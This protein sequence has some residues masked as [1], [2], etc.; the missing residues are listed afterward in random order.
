M[1]SDKRGSTVSR[2]RRF[3]E[4]PWG[5]AHGAR[6]LAWFLCLVSVTLL[7]GTSVIVLSSRPSPEWPWPSYLSLIFPV[8]FVVLGA[9]GA[10]VASRRPKNILGWLFVTISCINSFEVAGRLYVVAFDLPARAPVALV[11]GLVG[12]VGIGLLAAALLLFPDGRLPSPTW[13]P[14]AWV[15]FGSLGGC[16][17]LEGLQP[18][19]LQ[20]FVGV[21]NPIGVPG[22]AAITRQASDAFVFLIGAALALAALSLIVR[23]RRTRG[24]E[25]QQI[26]WLAFAAMVLVGA[27]PIMLG[28]DWYAGSY[29]MLAGLI[30]LPA[31]VGIA[32]LRYRLYDIDVII[33]RTLVYGS[34][35]AVLAGLFAALSIL[36]QRIVLALTGQESQAAVVLA[37]LVVTGLFQPLRSRVQTIVDRRFYRRKYDASQTLER[38]A[39]QLREEVELDR[40]ATGLVGV[41]RDTMQ[42]AHAF[43]WLR[44]TAGAEAVRGSPRQPG[45]REG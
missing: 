17:F 12:N 25:R 26:K 2:A 36:T 28:Y 41:V 24:V 42:P 18:G 27:V 37:A 22:L 23:V 3:V 31:A 35:T 43:L 33:N 6:L 32:I 29:V 14:F 11:D 15:I 16:C 39:L 10:V 9:V 4:R 8:P 21:D 20:W 13:R 45:A 38:F 7:A 44:P 34:V 30:A 19:E 1:A 40:L 5:L